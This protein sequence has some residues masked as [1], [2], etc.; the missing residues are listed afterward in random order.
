MPNLKSLDQSLV[1]DDMNET[2][3]TITFNAHIRN[4]Y[5]SCIEC[6]EKTKSV[7]SIHNRHLQDLPIQ[8][9]TVYIDIKTRHM[10]CRNCGKIFT[11]PMPFAE[12][13]AHMTN[14]LKEYIIFVAT[15]NSSIVAT[16]QL[17]KEG[18][19]I[20]KSSICDFLKKNK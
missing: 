15:P 13:T 10:H 8:H 19:I 5:V 18:I 16:K 17:K 9:K 6:G 2:E 7:H 3:N 12:N 1:V 4:K 20:E 14:R 11:E